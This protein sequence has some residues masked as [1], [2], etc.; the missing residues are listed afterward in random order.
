MGEQ[1]LTIADAAKVIGI[2]DRVLRHHI[3]MGLLETVVVKKWEITGEKKMSIPKDD[4]Q[5][6]KLSDATAYAA[7]LLEARKSNPAG[8][9]RKLREI[10]KGPNDIIETASPPVALSESDL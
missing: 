1:F 2:S 8:H 4:V 7:Y 10:I 9:L 5:A 3:R 6:V